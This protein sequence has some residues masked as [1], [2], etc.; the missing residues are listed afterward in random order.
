[1]KRAWL[2]VLIVAILVAGGVAAWF[3][4]QWF[5]WVPILVAA[6]VVALIVFLVVQATGIISRE[7]PK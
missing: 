2:I 1:M 7:E 3:A 4:I 5:G 6:P